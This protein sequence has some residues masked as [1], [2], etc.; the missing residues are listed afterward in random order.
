M[1]VYAYSK[2]VFILV[3]LIIFCWI[4]ILQLPDSKFH[5]IACDVGQGDGLI[6]I[7]K[8][9]QIVT[10]GGNPNGKINRC[11]SRYLP[12][13]DREIEVVI[14][15]HPQL[16]HYGGLIE[17]FKNYK[18]DNFV[19]ND[20]PV[21]SLEYQVLLKE[22]GRG[23]AKVIRPTVGTTL[24]LDLMQYDIFY[25]IDNEIRGDVN[26]V[27]VQAILTMGEFEAL[28]TGDIESEVS[29]LV[30]KNLPNKSIDYIKVP[31]HGSRNSMLSNYLKVIDPK[32]AVISVGKNNSYGHP[33]PEILKML[34]DKNIKILRTDQV[35]DVIVTS[36]GKNFWLEN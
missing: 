22:V 30:L 29:D 12:F 35:G 16:D 2:F 7:Y 33:H 3:F 10:D 20:I 14:N 8:N 34:S 36:D 26:N 9:Y 18:V 13:W 24:R 32:I 15:T 31:H 19:A 5:L 25:P 4:V 28:L 27:S 17:V 1:V 6:A 21:S 11:L 23:G